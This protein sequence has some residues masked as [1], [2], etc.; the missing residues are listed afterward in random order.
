MAL[1]YSQSVMLF[2]IISISNVTYSLRQHLR[3]SLFSPLQWRHSWHCGG[4]ANIHRTCSWRCGFRFNGGLRREK[5]QIIPQRSNYQSS[6]IDNTAFSLIS[7]AVALW[8][9][10]HQ[11][12]ALK[13]TDTFSELKV[14]AKGS[15]GLPS[16]GSRPD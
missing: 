16:Y 13:D 4:V 2:S 6:T 15:S 11:P 3:W 7:G 1:T 5:G 8:Q 10:E 14:I 9:C 12:L